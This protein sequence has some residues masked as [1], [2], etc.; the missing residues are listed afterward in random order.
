MLGLIKLLRDQLAVPGQNRV[1]LDDAG[2]LLQRLFPSIGISKGIFAP[3]PRPHASAGG[4]PGLAA[5]L[6]RR[7]LHESD[8]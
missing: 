7:H 6:Q 8:R 3:P 5:V 1:R 4:R 2:H